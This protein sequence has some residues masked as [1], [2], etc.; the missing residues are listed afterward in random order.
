VRD[1]LDQRGL[2]RGEIDAAAVSD[3]RELPGD[4]YL[5]DGEFG[6]LDLTFHYRATPHAGIY[7]T[8]PWFS[9][10][11]GF[12]DG[13][14]EGFHEE[15]GF[16]SAGRETV[17]RDRFFAIADLE[18]TTVVVDGRP[19]SG[20]GDPVVALR[21]SLLRRPDRYNLVLEAAAKV[22]VVER[23][24]FIATGRDDFGLQLSLQRFLRRN[25][26]YLSAAGVYYR[27]PDPGFAADGWI[28]TVVAGWETKVARNTNFI[29]QGYGSRSSVQRS[30]LAELSATKIQVTLGL[31]RTYRG[32][33]L[34]FGITENVANYDNT[35]DLGFNLS[36]G[37][38]VFGDPAA[39]PGRE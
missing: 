28:P 23:E 35:P 10:Q 39:G 27:P 29:L 24:A 26:L 7:V 6:V 33:V 31:Q 30:A 32:H 37:R 2:S 5:V 16:S 36:V 4:A 18:H 15:A 20:L 14:I 12:L 34:R 22:T 1:Y 25:A 3:I 38:I 21:Y 17:P 13:T 19:A 11:G 8:V 9:F